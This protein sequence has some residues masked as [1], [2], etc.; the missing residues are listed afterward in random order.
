MIDSRI[1]GANFRTR[2][3]LQTP[4][5]Q[6]TRRDCH[7]VAL[8]GATSQMSLPWIRQSSVLMNEK[9]IFLRMGLFQALLHS[10]RQIFTKHFL[11]ARHGAWGLWTQRCETHPGHQVAVSLVREKGKCSAANRVL[12][13]NREDRPCCNLGVLTSPW[14]LYPWS[15]AHC[16]AYSRHSI[17]A[18]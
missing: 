7:P 10:M 6:S 18:H 13:G 2:T 5:E 3:P 15:F 8:T 9:I 16:L 12:W 4:G 17:S 11:H 1:K 14:I